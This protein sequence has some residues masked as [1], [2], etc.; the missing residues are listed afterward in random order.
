[1]LAVEP[2][3]LL[4]VLGILGDK[5]HMAY[6]LYAVEL[7]YLGLGKCD[8]PAVESEKFRVGELGVM[9][10][11]NIVIGISNNGISL[12]LIDLLDLL[13]GQSTVGK[14]GVTVKICFVEVS[15]FGEQVLFHNVSSK[16]LKSASLT[17]TC[18]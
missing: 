14:N 13:G 4:Y 16:F 6:A 18:G 17:E 5:A 8:L 7:V 9:R 1:M 3:D 15:R 10:N 12:V 11:E 2:A